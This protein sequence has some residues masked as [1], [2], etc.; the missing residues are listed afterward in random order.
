MESFGSKCTNLGVKENPSETRALQVMPMLVLFYAMA[1]TKIFGNNCNLQQYRQ[2]Y[3]Y[4]TVTLFVLT[5]EK[6]NPPQKTTQSADHFIVA[7]HLCQVVSMSFNRLLKEQRW[8]TATYR[9]MTFEV[10]V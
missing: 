2:Q 10:K 5:A 9:Y 8:K 4:N 3:L 1:Q 6:R 7:K